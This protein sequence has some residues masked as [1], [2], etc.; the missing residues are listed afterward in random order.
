MKWTL[1][2]KIDRFKTVWG[3]LSPYTSTRIT[4]VKLL[5]L[6]GLQCDSTDKNDHI[7]KPSKRPPRC[8]YVNIDPHS[9]YI[10]MYGFLRKNSKSKAKVRGMV[11]NECSVSLIFVLLL[12]SVIC[13]FYLLPYKENVGPP[14]LRFSCNI[15]TKLMCLLVFS[16][17]PIFQKN[18]FS[19]NNLP[20][21]DTSAWFKSSVLFY[22]CVALFCVTHRHRN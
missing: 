15:F 3:G 19:N 7:S 9:D 17:H 22:F 4:K 20:F 1:S 8:N 21:E 10:P 18:L 14:P 11:W 12:Q 6:F 13:I 5:F 16:V 2:D